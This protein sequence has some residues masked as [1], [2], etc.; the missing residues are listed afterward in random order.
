MEV[1]CNFVRPITKSAAGVFDSVFERA[2]LRYNIMYAVRNYISH[3]M[4]KHE[5]KV[6]I[7]LSLIKY[8]QASPEQ[9]KPN[10]HVHSSE[11]ILC[12]PKG[13]KETLFHLNKE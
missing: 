3:P 10:D 8:F 6:Q 11:R 9:S 2:S 7:H 1:L 4:T 5:H 12:I 13:K